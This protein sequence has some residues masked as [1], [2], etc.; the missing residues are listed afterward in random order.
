MSFTPTNF[1]KSDPIIALRD[2]EHAAKLFNTDQFRLA[3]KFDFLFH[4]SFGINITALKSTDLVQRYGSE[5]N[6]LVKSIDLPTF[7]VTVDTVN[8]YNRKKN[9]QST[10]SIGEFAV[11]FH[12]DNM[13]LINQL[14]QNYYSYYFADSN[15]AKSQGAYD[16]NATKSSSY[17]TTPY[18]LDNNST[19][20]F[21]NYIKI[22]Q[23]ARHEYVCY[24][25]VNPIISSWAHRKM[26]YFSNK[27]HDNDMKIKAEA[28]TYSADTFGA[29]P[30]EGIDM[31][32]YDFTPSPL[33]GTGRNDVDPS[34]AT[35]LDLAN[36]APNFLNNAIQ[37][38]NA[39]QNTPSVTA[40]AG[41][42]GI[43]NLASIQTL[44]GIPGVTFP[45]AQSVIQQPTLA[46][47]I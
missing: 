25:L 12:D 22:Y 8:Q 14:W 40:P 31:S 41:I 16:R 15:S 9:I 4:V 39:Y 38:V 28:V 47:L 35:G 20:P 1:L 42:A 2:Q 33:S 13:G 10:H 36:S 43:T 19:A 23:M 44:G 30:P 6:M 29:N 24:T 21:F 46:S 26:D 27:T 5:I 17:I 37:T 7:T 18:G 11:V 32:H 45:Q 34:F 3:P